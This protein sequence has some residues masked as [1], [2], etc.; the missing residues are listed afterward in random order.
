MGWGERVRAGRQSTNGG[1]KWPNHASTKRPVVYFNHLRHGPPRPTTGEQSRRQEAHCPGVTRHHTGGGRADVGHVPMTDLYNRQDAG[2][3]LASR[4]GWL[5]DQEVLWATSQ[6]LLEDGWGNASG[7]HEEVYSKGGHSVV[8]APTSACW[9]RNLPQLIREVGKARRA[10]R[11]PPGVSRRIARRETEGATGTVLTL[12]QATGH[13]RVA[14]VHHNLSTCRD[15]GSC[16]P[17]A[18]S[19]CW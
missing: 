11:V 6:L 3:G 16:Q 10:E 18:L 1:K 15:V 9:Q 7:A 13:W 17:L 2:S 12:H 4:T 19:R 8:V 14:L 5:D